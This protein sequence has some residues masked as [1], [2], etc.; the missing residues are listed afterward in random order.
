M[1][2]LLQ[3]HPLSCL[4]LLS[5][6]HDTEE[7]YINKRANKKQNT[8]ISVVPDSWYPFFKKKKKKKKK[9]KK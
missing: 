2:E 1:R 6:M 4:G 3:M 5:L 7:E 9:R 8:L